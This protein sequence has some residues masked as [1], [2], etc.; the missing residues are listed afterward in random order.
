MYN[1]ALLKQGALSNDPSTVSGATVLC[2]KLP[3]DIRRRFGKYKVLKA[4]RTLMALSILL[5]TKTFGITTSLGIRNHFV[6]VF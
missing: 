5:R 1:Y 3:Q 6:N 2:T 4:E